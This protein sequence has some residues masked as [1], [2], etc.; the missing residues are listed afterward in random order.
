MQ[1]EESQM[2]IDVCLGS[3]KESEQECRA[4]YNGQNDPRVGVLAGEKK[5]L[6]FIQWRGTGGASEWGRPVGNR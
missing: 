6:K 2:Q 4:Y 3:R 1:D 5:G